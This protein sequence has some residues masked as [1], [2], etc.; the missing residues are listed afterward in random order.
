[1]HSGDGL[2]AVRSEAP[3]DAADRDAG[4]PVDPLPDELDLVVVPVEETLLHLPEVRPCHPRYADP[5]V[6]FSNGGVSK[7]GLHKTTEVL[8]SRLS[9]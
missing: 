2:G 8:Y 9:H 6:V 4:A 3:H 7:T 5:L 1:M